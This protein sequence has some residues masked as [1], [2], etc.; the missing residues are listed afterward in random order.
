MNRFLPGLAKLLVAAAALAVVFAVVYPWRGRDCWLP[1]T[2]GVT[3]SLR[4]ICAVSEQVCWASGSDGTVLRTIDGGVTWSQVGP[5]EAKAFDFRDVHAFDA[6][7]AIVMV[8]GDPDRI[9]RTV[10]GGRSW[11]LAYEHEDPAAFLDGLVFERDG[12]RGWCLGDPLQGR[13][14]LLQ[15][16]DAG[17]TWQ[18]VDPQ[19]LP[20][21]PEGV[22][23]FAASGSSL[24]VTAAGQLWI[25]LGGCAPDR[26]ADLAWI[27]ASDDRGQ[28]WRKFEVPMVANASSGIFSLAPLDDQGTG[29]LAA[30]GDYNQPGLAASNLIFSRDG[31]NTWQTCEGT[32][33]PRGFRSALARASSGPETNLWI[34]VGPG[35]TDLSRDDGATWQAASDQGFHTLSFVHGTNTGWAAGSGGRIA[36]WQP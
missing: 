12:Q 23:A 1:Q 31:G 3:S 4:G 35:G 6:D 24:A 36:R 34:A 7:R 17:A 16:T 9:Y 28:T 8:A 19:T 32:T 10:D 20:E 25:G 14:F 27:C 26:D 30:G 2:S 29:W 33:G 11:S 21:L 22:A 15:T 5:A 13:M 18:P